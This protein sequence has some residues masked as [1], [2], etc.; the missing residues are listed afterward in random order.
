MNIITDDYVP[1]GVA[2]LIAHDGTKP[3]VVLTAAGLAKLA[4][5]I[6]TIKPPFWKTTE[7]PPQI[8]LILD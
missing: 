6:N 7:D 1:A 2:Y 5:H 4:E 8:P 3:T